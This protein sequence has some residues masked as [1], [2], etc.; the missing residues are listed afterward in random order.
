M[1]DENHVGQYAGWAALLTAAGAFSVWMWH[2]IAALWTYVGLPGRF[3][4]LDG[5]LKAVENSSASKLEL[6]ALQDAFGA[7][8][9]EHKKE[10]NGSLD[11]VHHQIAQVRDLMARGDDL[12]RVEGKLDQLLVQQ[13]QKQP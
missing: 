13:F 3:D 2:R 5:R 11:V 4:A 8:L 10:V 6:A 1:A 7:K 9:D 12:K